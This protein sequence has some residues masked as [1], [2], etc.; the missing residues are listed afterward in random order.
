M[1]IL[2]SQVAEQWQKDFFVRKLSQHELTFLD[3][4][5]TEENVSSYAD[6]EILSVF[7]ND[8]VGE[9]ILSKLPNLTHIATRS[10][11]YDHIDLSATKN[12]NV[13]VSNVPFYGE[14]TVAEH[15]MALLLALARKLP[16]SMA[17]IE[18]GKFTYEGLQGWDLK[19]KT[20]GIVGGGHI[21]MNLAR[22][23]K[24]FSMNV[25]V[26]DLYPVESLAQEIGFT[27][28]PFDDLLKTSDVIS[29]HLPL[30]EHTNHIIGEEAIAKMKDGVVF[31]NTARGGLVD[32]EALVQGFALGK[33]SGAGLDVLE[34]EDLLKDEISV[35]TQDEDKRLSGILLLDH[36]LM[37]MENVIV[38]PHNAFNSREAVERIMQTTVDNINSVEANSPQNLV[39]V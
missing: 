5:L 20:I 22:M 11:G 13:S 19:D 25:I 27:Y 35:A 3:D 31:I 18:D 4:E 28:V 29:L 1:H 32:T 34:S 26:Y 24:G 8:K 30:N 37:E 39:T 10:T 33:I 14:N 12:H 17:R 38:T 21:G 15:A 7:V 2:F 23:A 16:Q 6:T 9:S 36:I